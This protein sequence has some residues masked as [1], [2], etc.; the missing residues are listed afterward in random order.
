MRTRALKN[1]LEALDGLKPGDAVNELS[2][3]G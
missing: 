2:L 1:A 3:A